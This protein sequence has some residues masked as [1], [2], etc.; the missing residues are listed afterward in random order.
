LRQVLLNLI[1]NAIKFTDKGYVEIGVQRGISFPEYLEFYIRDTGVGIPQ[2]R[3]ESV[4]DPFEQVDG[5]T[6]RTYG[7]TGLGL[8]IVSR[9]IRLMGGEIKVISQLGKGS[10]FHFQIPYKPVQG[11]VERPLKTKGTDD[12]QISDEVKKCILVAEDNDLNYRLI[13]TILTKKDFDVV[14]ARNGED[15]VSIYKTERHGIDLILMDIHMP[16]LGGLEATR[17]IREQHNDGVPI[18]A[19]TAYAMKGDRERFLKA[20]CTDYISKPLKPSELL[21][22][23][24]QCIK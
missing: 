22:K 19:T 21:E 18:I 10:T 4:F 2:E 1:G 9:L 17:V 7:G 15:A 13:E 12:S 3:L 6:T 24:E 16:V 11:I 23:I 5:S 14:R 20:G 8:A